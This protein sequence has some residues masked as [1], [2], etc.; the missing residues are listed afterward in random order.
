[1]FVTPN[2][3]TEIFEDFKQDT[4]DRIVVL[5]CMTEIRVVLSEEEEQVCIFSDS[6]SRKAKVG[7]RNIEDINIFMTPSGVIFFGF[8]LWNKHDI[9]QYYNILLIR[10]II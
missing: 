8:V 2:I 3:C 6:L 1:M 10:V 5:I 4:I 7:L 9:I